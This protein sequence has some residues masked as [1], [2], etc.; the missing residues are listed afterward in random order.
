MSARGADSDAAGAAPHA[1]LPVPLPNSYWVV[2]GRLLAGEYPGGATV[3]ETRARL[4]RLL[5]AGIDYFLDLTAPEELEPYEYLL[6]ASVGHERKPIPDHG[7]PRER[8]H[9]REILWYLR[10]AL[11]DGRCVYLHCRAG[12]GRTGMTVAC[13]LIEEGLESAAALERLSALWSRSAR[14]SSWP[15]VPETDEQFEYVQAWRASLGEPSPAGPAVAAEPGDAPADAPAAPIAIT[16]RDRFLGA[17][18]GLA[19]GD[20]LAA[21]TQSRHRGTFSPVGDLLGGGPFDLP[22]GA[23]SDDTAM[24][25][26]LA[27]SLAERGGFD[28]R[29]QVERYLRWQQEGH[30]SA[31]GQCVGITPSVARA[32]ATAQWRRQLYS[33]SHDP[34]RLDAEPLARLTPVVMCYFGNAAEAVRL[35]GESARPTCQAPLV[36][37][38]CRLFGAMLHAALSG[39]D[40]AAV[41]APAEG[42]WGGQPLR[43]QVQAI[44]A[45]SYRGK[46]AARIRSGGD[47]LYVLEAV[48]WAFEGGRDF[49]EAVLL[50]ANLGGDSDVVTSACGA[51]AGA[52]YG[53]QSIPAVWRSRLAGADRI[54]EL[55]ERLLARALAGRGG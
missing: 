23:W 19:A 6:P 15:A 42:C 22:R 35:A 55:S 53:V 24:A 52:H 29:D 37:D 3:E 38:A 30:L 5:D 16:L 45:G 39:A 14:S 34:Q 7:V 17:L 43:P 2:P 54:V 10:Q 21:A 18:L 20:A 32:L 12:I 26:C 13:H 27:E 50:A 40:K 8:A 4:G 41:L 48:L 28:V 33:G 1:D 47:I 11:A 31:T 36:I 25:L 49:R 46:T 44:A 9:M 51:L